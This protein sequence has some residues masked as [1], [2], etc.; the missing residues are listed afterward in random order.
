MKVPA[1]ISTILLLSSFLIALAFVGSP[2]RAADTGQSPAA[3]Q[4]DTMQ[5]QAYDQNGKPMTKEEFDKAYKAH[6]KAKINATENRLE[7]RQSRWKKN[8]QPGGS[9]DQNATPQK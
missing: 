7:A 3:G 8:E 9:Q 1:T 6:M 4:A 2:A 5:P